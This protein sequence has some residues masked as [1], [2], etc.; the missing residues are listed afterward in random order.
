[1]IARRGFLTGLAAAFAAP[2]IVKA[3]SLMPVKSYSDVDIYKLLAERIW[4]AEKI[5]RA[6]M[7][8]N[9]FYGTADA[10]LQFTGFKSATAFDPRFS[11][12]EI[13]L[14]LVVSR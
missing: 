8:Q 11:F 4:E 12:K 1:M 7:A 5:L 2:A 6:S 13:G 9:I 14:Q 3:S 10:P